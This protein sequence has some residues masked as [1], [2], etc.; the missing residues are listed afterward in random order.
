LVI[1]SKQHEITVIGGSTSPPAPPLEQLHHYRIARHLARNSPRWQVR[2]ISYF[3]LGH[4]SK[5]FLEVL[6]HCPFWYPL[7]SRGV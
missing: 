4:I 1:F 3:S 5:L 6:E 2:R 7:S